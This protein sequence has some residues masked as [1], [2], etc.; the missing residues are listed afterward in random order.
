[1]LICFKW[2]TLFEIIINC[3]SFRW[4]N[5]VLTRLYHPVRVYLNRT[6][7]TN[8]QVLR[9]K[10]LIDT[11]VL[12]IEEEC[13]QF[14]KDF[15]DKYRGVVEI[16]SSSLL[17]HLSHPA[18]IDSVKTWGKEDFI[19][20]NLGST[21]PTIQEKIDELIDTRIGGIMHSWE[22][23][24][25]M[26]NRNHKD[27]VTFIGRRGKYISDQLDDLETL[28]RSTSLAEESTN[29][30]ELVKRLPDRLSKAGCLDIP[31]EFEDVEFFKDLKM[32]IAESYGTVS[33]QQKLIMQKTLNATLMAPHLLKAFRKK[34]W[35][36]KLTHTGVISTN[37]AKW[38]MSQ[39]DLSWFWKTSRALKWSH[40]W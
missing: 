36:K 24:H 33:P 11:K 18:T 7:Q 15:Y 3:I 20:K 37:K 10:A 31:E 38:D 32:L 16:I 26:M 25:Q 2:C 39:A 5:N 27:M 35:R 4:L 34:K 28:I 40:S 19:N 13:H 30:R 14:V 8:E 6:F 29:S 9:K 22:R 12:A 23:Q 21:W 17:E 1:M